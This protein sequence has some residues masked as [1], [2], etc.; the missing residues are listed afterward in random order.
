MK[1]FTRLEAIAAPL[2]RVNIDTDAIIPSREMKRVSKDGLGE[3]LFAGW[4][5]TQPGSR[6]ENPGFVLNRP[7]Y[8]RAE[9]LLAG[10]NFGCGS[11][12]EHA[13]WALKEWGVRC[14]VA[15]SFGAIF[16]ANCVRNGLLPLVLEDASIARLVER[17]ESD[18]DNAKLAVDLEQ[19]TISGGDDLTFDF[20]VN[21]ADRRMLLEGL[22][23]IALTLRHEAEITA[24]ERVDQ[25]LRPWAVPT[26]P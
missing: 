10:D 23:S 7:P 18:P 20:Q 5:Y 11:S 21:P 4:R 15:P 19:Q 13:V 8:R 2:R 14:I 24:F 1:P 25:D 6:E 22:D 26:A 12:R 16:A 3:G 17:V 9:I